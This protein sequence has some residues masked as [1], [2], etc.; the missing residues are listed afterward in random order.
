MG[1]GAQWHF[2]FEQRVELLT[3]RREWPARR[4]ETGKV[5][6][7]WRAERGLQI[8]HKR[9][10]YTLNDSKKTTTANQLKNI[11]E[12]TISFIHILCKGNFVILQSTKV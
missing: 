2:K 4:G 8:K 12:K 3:A 5:A 10:S 11:N 7:V 9:H 6:W 1:R